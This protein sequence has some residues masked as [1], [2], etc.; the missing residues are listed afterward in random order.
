MPNPAFHRQAC[1]APCRTGFTLI[2]LLV[3]ISIIALLIGILLPAL[4]AARDAARGMKCLS[5]LKQFGIADA[6]YAAENKATLV[7]SVYFNEERSTP[8]WMWSDSRHFNE[9]VPG[10]ATDVSSG[11]DR[12]KITSVPGTVYQCPLDEEF[13]GRYLGW[14][15]KQQ[16]LSY[17]RNWRLGYNT[18]SGPFIPSGSNPATPRYA[19]YV[20]EDSIL[21]A[22]E[23]MS[24]MDYRSTAP[25]SAAAYPEGAAYTDSTNQGLN[26][27][28]F[29]A[30]W[31]PEEQQNALFV[32][33]HASVY[34]FDISD[35]SIMAET[36][37]P[38]V[39]NF[40]SGDFDA[41]IK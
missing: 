17:G 39:D 24:I 12:W 15:G 2:E 9:S 23:M 32:D 26:S 34:N 33:G 27:R 7:P 3:V 35:D 1:A 21:S 11:S 41:F 40:W 10:M 30:N 14:S 16:Y 36:E 5:N 37:D 29:W 31:H 22:T 20:R 6:A 13:D 28:L 25:G 18:S 38:Q 4:G 19:P 8:G